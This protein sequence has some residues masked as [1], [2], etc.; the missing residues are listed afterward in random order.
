MA[1]TTRG[2]RAKNFAMHCMTKKPRGGFLHALMAIGQTVRSTLMQ[3]GKNS[4]E[5]DT[6]MK[7]MSWAAP[8]VTPTARKGKEAEDEI[9]CLDAPWCCIGGNEQVKDLTGA[10]GTDAFQ[11]SGGP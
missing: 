8:W 4:K 5:L 2:S 10:V 9:N 11:L 6:A 7:H 1:D 3:W